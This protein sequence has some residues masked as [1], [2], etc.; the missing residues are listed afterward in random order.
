MDLNPQ[1][2]EWSRAHGPYEIADHCIST[3]SNLLILLN[4]WLDSGKELDETHD[5]STL[6]YWALRTRP[7]WS[8]GNDSDS[9]SSDEKLGIS[10][11]EQGTSGEEQGISDEKQGTL[12]QDQDTP[13]SDPPSNN[14]TLVIICNRTGQ[15]NGQTSFIAFPP[16]LINMITGK[17][18]AGSSAIFS[19]QPASGR[20]KLL[21]MMGR[22]EEGVYIWNIQT[23]SS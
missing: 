12:D 3:K 1:I 6:N 5:W 23:S 9:S 11:E 21:G 2:P 15:E 16:L 18:F 19:M 14:E 17:T 7:L 4:A 20:P 13:T 8:N 10:N 22:R